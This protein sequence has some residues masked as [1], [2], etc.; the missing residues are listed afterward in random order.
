MARSRTACSMA[1]SAAAAWSTAGPPPWAMSGRP[2]P[3]WPPSAATPA[4]T[5]SRASKRLAE[6]VGHRDQVGRLALVGGDDGDDAGADLLLEVVGQ[7]LQFPRRHAL[8]DA[9]GELD[10]VHVLG[11]VAVRRR[12]RTQPPSAR[13]RRASPARARACGALP[14]ARRSAPAVPPAGPSGCRRLR[15]A[16]A[17][18]RPHSRQPPLPVSASMRRTPAATAPSPTILNRPISPVRRTWVPPQSSVE[19]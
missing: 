18:A 12:D 2:P 6:V 19:K 15:S 8:E 17:R 3:P 1:S 4:F 7:A 13:A 5:S 9:G 11:A 10:A 16:C 14:P